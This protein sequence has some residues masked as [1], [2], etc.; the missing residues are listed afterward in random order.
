MRA[1]S[2]LIACGQTCIRHASTSTL[3]CLVMNETGSGGERDELPSRALICW[4]P[5]VSREH[6]TPEYWGTHAPAV[7][8]FMTIFFVGALVLN[9]FIL[10]SMVRARSKLLRAPTHI[11]LFSLAVNDLLLTV[12][13]MP[14]S[15]VTTIAQDYPFGTNDNIRCKVCQHGGI[16]TVLSVSS[17]HHI[18]LLSLD[19]FLFIYM[20]FGY[21]TWVSR[22][23]MPC[24]L[25]G[26]W[27]ISIIIGI[28]PLFGF[29]VV[30]YSS[31]IGTCVAIFHGVTHLTDNIS[32]VL[33]FFVEA[34]IPITVIVVCN[35]GLICTARKHL[36]K[37]RA[38]RKQMY[39]ASAKDSKASG[40]TVETE[41]NREHKQ[42][43]LQLFKVFTA[44]F[45]GNIITWM[46]VL[47]L[48]LA[49]QVIDFDKVTSEAIAFVYMTYISYALI[50]PLLESWFII[51]IRVKAKKLLCCLCNSKRFQ[52]TV[53]NGKA[54][55]N[56]CTHSA[57][58]ALLCMMPCLQK[59][60]WTSSHQD[61]SLSVASATT[62]IVSSTM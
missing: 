44:I 37:I 59:E 60:G 18:A 23:R 2:P 41:L 61:P 49:S 43:Q 53:L 51:D 17:I 39:S 32:Y 27:L 47:G 30:G 13:V 21:K 36:K 5:N 8:V 46:P 55:K 54:H 45:I 29:G 35:I 58:Q 14:V 6:T 31:S 38:A 25:L 1:A 20:P 11:V 22:W 57:H 7:A 9:S 28:L 19:R 50:H 26:V 12:L 4:L 34:L 33:L 15:I 42:Q 3:S 62:D 24:A 16:F 10:Y 40:G 48:A 56:T 52:E